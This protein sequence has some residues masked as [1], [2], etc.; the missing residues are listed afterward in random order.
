MF[1]HRRCSLLA[2][3][4]P[5][6]VGVDPLRTRAGL[7]LAALALS[8]GCV[9]ARTDAALKVGPEV[10]QS[11]ERFRKEYVL[12]P[13]D[14]VDV[15]VR[16]APE[17]SRAVA[18][19][20]DGF[21]SLPILDDVKAAGLTLG[22]FDARVTELLAGRLVDPEVSILAIELRQ[23]VV[24]VIGDVRQPK[25][26]PVRDAPTAL[27]AVAMAGG[28]MRSAAQTDV[29][30]I[31][32]GEDGYLRATVVKTEGDGQPAPY[33]ALG[34]IPLQADDI[35]FVPEGGRSQITRFIN[36]LIVQPMM[37]VNVALGIVA[38]YKL[39]QELNRPRTV[40]VPGPE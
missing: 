20:P 9:S 26:L 39:V 13:G 14:K 36:D 15:I 7:A 29:A 3:A 32:L 33:L 10:I 27:Q 40:I 23:P 37:P 16:R 21:V 30:I 6:P 34:G 17:V 11:A 38:N 24:H 19:R 35:V 8:G 5:R 2:G 4:T 31:R 28:L 22:E 25:T 18:V 12:A 1:G